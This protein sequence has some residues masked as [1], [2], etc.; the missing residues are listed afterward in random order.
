MPIFVALLCALSAVP[1]LMRSVPFCLTVQTLPAVTSISM[2][3][4]T[5][6]VPL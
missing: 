5:L 2:V 1:G 4:P 6:T 3:S